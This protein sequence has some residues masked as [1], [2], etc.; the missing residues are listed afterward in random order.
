[1]QTVA[2]S[3]FRCPQPR[4]RP[5]RVN[6][7]T[8]PSRAELPAPAAALTARTRRKIHHRRRNQP[9]TPARTPPTTNSIIAPKKPLKKEPTLNSPPIAEP[10]VPEKNW[11]IPYMMMTMPM[12]VSTAPTRTTVIASQPKGSAAGL[13]WTR[14]AGPSRENMRTRPRE[15]DLKAPPDLL[16]PSTPFPRP[17]LTAFAIAVRPQRITYRDGHG[18]T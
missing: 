5:S 2:R 15:E 10:I 16:N 6:S 12:I 17:I 3:G 14:L 11:N 1:M 4:Q 8:P 13:L 9:P 18:D 7:G